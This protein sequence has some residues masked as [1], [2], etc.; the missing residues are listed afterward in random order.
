MSSIMCNI[1]LNFYLYVIICRMQV[2][3]DHELTIFTSDYHGEMSG[4]GISE[5]L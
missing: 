2:V 1:K 4:E 3:L 5:L